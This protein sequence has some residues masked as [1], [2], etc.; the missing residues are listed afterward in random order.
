MDIEKAQMLEA[1]FNQITFPIAVLKANIPRFTIVAM[2]DERRNAPGTPPDAV[3]RD[4]FD[5]YKPWDKGS[6]EQ[7]ARLK[8]GL[9][10]AIKEK[11]QVKLPLLYFEVPVPGS[12]AQTSRLWGSQLGLPYCW[13]TTDH[14]PCRPRMEGRSTSEILPTSGI[15]FSNSRGRSG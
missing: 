10:E 6:E 4:A 15:I 11:K 12:T 13:A 8:D 9:I 2:N 3:G 1:I 7:L 14:S 5:V